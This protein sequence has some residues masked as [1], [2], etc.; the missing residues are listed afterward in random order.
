MSRRIEYTMHHFSQSNPQGPD[1]ENVPALL[2]RVAETIEDLG[3]VEVH[4]LVMHTDITSDGLSPHFT[5]YFDYL[6]E[7]QEE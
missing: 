4:D 5:V 2:R 7:V 1:Q 6:D 3:D